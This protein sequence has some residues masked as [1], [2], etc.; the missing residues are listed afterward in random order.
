MN[1]TIRQLR[2]FVAAAESGS[3]SAAARRL[4]V[5]PSAL[6]LLVK[7]LERV[8]GARLFERS[9]RNTR[10]C[11]AGTDFFPLAK[12]VLDDLARAVESAHEL[13]HK[14]RGTVRIACT[15]LYASVLL[16]ALIARYRERYPGIEVYVL[17]SLNQQALARVATGEADFGIAPQRPTPSGLEQQSLF[18]DRIV[19][20][21][22]PDH[23]LAKRSGVSWT[24]ALREPFVSLTPDFTARLRADLLKHSSEL[25]LEPAHHV[26]FLTT[27]LGMV[28]SGL[29]VTAQPAH[30]VRLVGSFGLVARK[31]TGPVVYRELSLFRVR[32][33]ALSAAATSF[34][35]FLFERLQ[36]AA[37][38]TRLGL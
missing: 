2:A 18:K 35:D 29:G 5:T 31:L 11:V 10:L 36:P 15:P 32:D 13:Q 6:S 33:Q 38:Q 9:T 14:R 28:E 3:F 27:A 20:I 25:V 37:A 23:V 21:C 7:E 4:H 16:P 30:A 12:K 26:S 19:L 1:V 24:R 22:R 34:R 17:D 8:L